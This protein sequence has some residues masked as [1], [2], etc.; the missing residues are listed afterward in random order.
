MNRATL[1]S[2]SLA[3]GLLLAL[4]PAGAQ[5]QTASGLS[6]QDRTF[7]QQAAQYNQTE[8]RL[9]RIA[10]RNSN[11]ED[12]IEYAQT[13]LGDHSDCNDRLMDIANKYSISLPDWSASDQDAEIMKMRDWRGDEFQRHYTTVELRNTHDGIQLFRNEAENG[14]DPQLRRFARHYMA[15]WKKNLN[16][17]K[18]IKREWRISGHI[19]GIDSAPDIRY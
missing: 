4:Y 9:A 13:M 19:D 2:S 18:D 5:A 7:I 8:M 11:D 15:T 3:A 16:L 14:T 10:M 6:D 17:D 12:V 1:I